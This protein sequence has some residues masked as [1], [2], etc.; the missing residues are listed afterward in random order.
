MKKILRLSDARLVS[1]TDFINNIA[2]TESN[3]NSLYKCLFLSNTSRKSQ[4]F[5]PSTSCFVN[6]EK[7][8]TPQNYKNKA[9][10][11]HE[12]LLMIGK[13][14]NFNHI[15]FQVL[16]FTLFVILIHRQ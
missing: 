4:Y 3:I 5:Y 9:Q 12:V 11:Y 8:R 6:V 2:Q 1:M 10:Q 16:I 14:N 13:F 7:S 15:L